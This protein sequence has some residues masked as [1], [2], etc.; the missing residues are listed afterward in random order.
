MMQS[1]QNGGGVSGD[2][3][4]SVVIGNLKIQNVNHTLI[5]VAAWSSFFPFVIFFP[6]HATAFEKYL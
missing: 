5:T 2:M 1:N 4:L 3:Y 6:L